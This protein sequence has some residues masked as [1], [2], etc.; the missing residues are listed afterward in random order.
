MRFSLLVVT[1][2]LAL[3]LCYVAL[4]GQV[5]PHTPAVNATAAQAVGDQASTIID[6][7]LS[8]SGTLGDLSVTLQIDP[9]AGGQTQLTVRVT[10]RHRPV[11]NGQVRIKLSRPAHAGQ[12]AAIVETTPASGAYM[13]TSDLVQEGLWRADVLV[14][15]HGD[16]REFRDVPL[17]FLAGVEPAVLSPPSLQSRYGPASLRLSSAPGAAARLGVRL[18]PGLRV[19]YLITMADMNPQVADARAG[20]NGWYVGAIV[21]PMQGYMNLAVQVRE[22][23]RWHTVRMTVCEVDAAYAMHVLL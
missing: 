19:R 21:P 17:V 12:G 11:T 18:R 16:P 8:A 10:E 20:A 14:R 6:S 3:V 23:G 5:A 7:P 2:L 9:A 1:A 13:G 22:D 4:M 15:T